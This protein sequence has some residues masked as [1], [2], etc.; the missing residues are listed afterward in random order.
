MSKIIIS[1][2]SYDFSHITNPLAKKRHVA[3][4]SKVPKGRLFAKQSVPLESLWFTPTR[5]KINIYILKNNNKKK[6]RWEGRASQL[7]FP[8]RRLHPSRLSTVREDNRKKWGK[9][10]Q[11]SLVV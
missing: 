4:E 8:M 6:A 5:R 3:G 7:P 10:L 9:L 11:S 2:G 1:H